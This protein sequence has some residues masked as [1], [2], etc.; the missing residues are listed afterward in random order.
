MGLVMWLCVSLEHVKEVECVV[1]LCEEH[2]P[3]EALSLMLLSCSDTV[4]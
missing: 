2:W 4:R 1:L 3:D